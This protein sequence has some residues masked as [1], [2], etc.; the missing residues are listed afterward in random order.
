MGA[1]KKEVEFLPGFWFWQVRIRKFENSQEL[2]VVLF[3]I[4]LDC[5]NKAT[6]HYFCDLKQILFLF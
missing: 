1:G 5:C 6:Q 2:K 3:R 4:E